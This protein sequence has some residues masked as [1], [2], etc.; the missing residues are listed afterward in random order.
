M[1]LRKSPYAFGATTTNRFG[2]DERAIVAGQN[3]LVIL[4]ESANALHFLQLRRLPPQQRRR[5]DD[6][7][8]AA[9]RWRRR[10]KCPPYSGSPQPSIQQ[11]Y[12]ELSGSG[13]QRDVRERKRTRVRHHGDIL[14]QF[15][16]Y[17]AP[18]TLSP[19]ILPAP[20]STCF[21]PCPAASLCKPS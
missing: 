5:L 12:G 16:V 4:A 9:I 11:R 18:C 19:W 14:T 8:D 13:P 15:L 20:R 21:V 1:K 3:D 7:D 2:D 17:T 6:D 10:S